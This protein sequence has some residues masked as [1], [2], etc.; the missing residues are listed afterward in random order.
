[1]YVAHNPP[2]FQR[3]AHSGGS[4]N[5]DTLSVQKPARY[6]DRGCDAPLLRAMSAHPAGESQSAIVGAETRHLA[7]LLVRNAG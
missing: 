2:A 4:R 6:R 7:R 5:L 3:L 1:M